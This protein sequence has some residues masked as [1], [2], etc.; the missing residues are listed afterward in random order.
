VNE[1]TLSRI[2]AEIAAG[3][4]GKARDRLHGLI[5]TYPNALEL[6][7]K[8]GD[9]YWQLKYP[10]M[11]GRYWYLA[12][13]KTP[14]MTEACRAFEKSCGNDPLQMLLALK[15]RGE[16][17][18]I[19]DT[20]AGRS[21]LALQK[22]VNDQRRQRIELGRRGREKYGESRFSGAGGKL[23]LAGC[24]VGALIA[25]VLMVAGLVAIVQWVF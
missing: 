16:F 7:L 20:S 9:V 22:Q 25:L 4:L 21:L 13:E 3:D 6:R 10:A 18:T 1:R 24:S 2:D 12:E 8:L 11:A 19:R 15:F 5:A 17:E 14:A 23:L